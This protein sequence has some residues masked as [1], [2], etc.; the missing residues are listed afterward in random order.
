MRD[1]YLWRG[2]QQIYVRS[3]DDLFKILGKEFV[4]VRERV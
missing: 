2:S 1:G 3:E 4:A